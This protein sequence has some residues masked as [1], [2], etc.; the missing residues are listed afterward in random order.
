MHGGCIPG[1]LCFPH[2]RMMF[3][4]VM[5]KNGDVKIFDLELISSR[6]SINNDDLV[7][8]KCQAGLFLIKS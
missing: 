5:R 6:S 1:G 7:G 4:M 3:D 8:N 2:P